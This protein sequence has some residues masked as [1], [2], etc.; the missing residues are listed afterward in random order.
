V[1]SPTVYNRRRRAIKLATS[2]IVVC[3]QLSRLSVTVGPMSA[4]PMSNARVGES[5]QE[6]EIKDS[7]GRYRHA[8]RA[9][10]DE[11]TLQPLRRVS[12]AGLESSLYV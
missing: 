3:T 2:T 12:K 5:G 11:Q 4:D 6:M 10:V 8:R 7:S 9:P 1:A